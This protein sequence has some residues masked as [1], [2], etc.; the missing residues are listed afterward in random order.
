ME[1]YPKFQWTISN[2]D[3]S[4]QWV[5]RTETFAEFTEAVHSMYKLFPLLKEPLPEKASEPGIETGE[6]PYCSLHRQPM[7]LRTAKSG[8]QWFD[9]RWKEGNIWYQCNGSEIRTNQGKA[10]NEETSSS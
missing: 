10:N 8:E 7:K 5:V 6:Q 1:H 9:H 4:Q 3:R 2:A